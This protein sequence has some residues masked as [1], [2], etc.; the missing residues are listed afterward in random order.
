[1]EILHES[2][3]PKA[4]RNCSQNHFPTWVH[5]HTNTYDGAYVHIVNAAA[6]TRMRIFPHFLL[7]IHQPPHAHLIQQP[8]NRICLCCSCNG[9]LAKCKSLYVAG[10]PAHTIT[11]S[12]ATLLYPIRPVYSSCTLQRTNLNTIRANFPH[13]PTTHRQT[14][15]G[16]SNVCRVRAFTYVSSLPL[17]AATNLSLAYQNVWHGPKCASGCLPDARNQTW[18]LCARLSASFYA[19][20]LEFSA[21]A[22]TA[23]MAGRC[24]PA[25]I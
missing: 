24:A 20:C 21:I 4:S 23:N 15:R 11:Q 14:M 10:N 16:T 5:L 9:L 13:F 22:S 2:S 8:E 25:N 19:G 17:P 6:S 7:V 18:V 1:M 12:F 3:E